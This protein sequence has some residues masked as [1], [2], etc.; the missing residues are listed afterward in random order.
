MV[1]SPL[2]LIGCLIW[3]MF[4][5]KN[6]I[7]P[8]LLQRSK[9]LRGHCST[10]YHATA[11]DYE[12]WYTCLLLAQCEESHAFEIQNHANYMYISRFRCGVDLVYFLVACKMKH[13]CPKLTTFCYNIS[14]IS[15]TTDN[16]MNMKQKYVKH[17]TN[18]CT[19]T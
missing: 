12:K 15:N 1:I 18:F 17:S 14:L 16:L 19:F 5:A 2:Q 3:P 13:C 10:L 11:Q 9:K 6:I 8:L 7:I 4:G